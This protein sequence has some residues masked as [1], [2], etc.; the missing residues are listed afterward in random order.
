MEEERGPKKKRERKNGQSI[1][2]HFWSSFPEK[3]IEIQLIM[4]HPVFR[5]KA[6]SE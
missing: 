6:L 1:V 3:V 2:L 4:H 5:R